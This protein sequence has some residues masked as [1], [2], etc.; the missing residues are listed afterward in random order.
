MAN[1]T[2]EMALALSALGLLVVEEN[3][4]LFFHFCLSARALIRL[5]EQPMRISFTNKPDCNSTCSSWERNRGKKEKFD[6]SKDADSVEHTKKTR[7]TNRL[8]SNLQLS[9][10]CVLALKVDVLEARKM[11]NGKDLNDFTG[12]KL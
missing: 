2:L 6:G 3:F 5:T 9:A 1:K 7:S 11:S 4:I 12:D 10:W 8:V